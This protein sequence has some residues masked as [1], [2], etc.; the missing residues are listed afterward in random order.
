MIKPK[1]NQYVLMPN[2]ILVDE[3]IIETKTGSIEK[4]KDTLIREKENWIKEGKPLRVA[5]AFTSEDGKI[6]IKENE[7]VILEQN[8]FGMIR[9]EFEDCTRWQ[10]SITSIAGKIVV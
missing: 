4:S 1:L 10:L 8:I 5:R 2:R 9:I 7:F 3:P 6:S